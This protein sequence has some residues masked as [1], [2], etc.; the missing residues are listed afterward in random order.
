MTV[1]AFFDGLKAL[2]GPEYGF[3]QRG[4]SLLGVS[5]ATLSHAHSRYKPLPAF[6]V[7]R[8]QAAQQAIGSPVDA[9]VGSRLDMVLSAAVAAGYDKERAAGAI[10][11]WA[12]LGPAWRP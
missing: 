10:F 5:Y 12:V 1:E 9:Y 7:E 8:L 2:V 3:L 6:H 4:A 11:A